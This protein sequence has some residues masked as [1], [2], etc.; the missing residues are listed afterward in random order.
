MEVVEVIYVD[1]VALGK[2]Q[3]EMEMLVCTS[4]SC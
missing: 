3:H 2:T 1:S 4:A